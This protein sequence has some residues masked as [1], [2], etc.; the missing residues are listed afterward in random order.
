METAVIHATKRP[1]VGTRAA[2]RLRREGQLPLALY[3]HQRDTMH[4]SVPLK[5]VE[6]LIAAG[7]RMVH[8]EIG[9]TVEMALLKELQY[10]SLGDHLVHLDLARVAMDEK[11]TVR[12][13]VELHGLAKGTLAGGTLSHSLKDVEVTCL[14]SDLP[15]KIRVEVADLGVG[16]VIYLRD[17]KPPEGVAFHHELDTPVVAVHAPLEAK[18]AVPA[19]AAEGAAEPEVIGR[20]AAEEGED[21]E[22][23][24]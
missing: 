21:K 23:K 22:K 17:L 18:E 8:V 6:R 20:R 12:V 4:L 3:G 11:V 15:E 16:Q 5:E 2:R 19:E 10:D 9:G 24:E 14:P 7:S 1:T 13:P